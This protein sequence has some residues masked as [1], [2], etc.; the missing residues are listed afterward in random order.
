MPQKKLKA[1]P[2]VGSDQPNLMEDLYIGKA[3][4][5]QALSAYHSDS[6]VAPYNP[7]DLYQKYNDYSI[8]EDMLIDDQVSVCVNIK[9]DLIVGS[10][11][12]IVTEEDGQ[13]EIQADVDK[14]LREDSE[15]PI[16]DMLE[17]IIS[18]YNFGFSISE[19][20]F[21]NRS[22]GSLTL[23]YAK[24]RHP[25]TWTIHTDKLGNVE[26][27]EQHGSET[28]IDVDPASV[29]H[30]IN[31]PNW[32]N[33]YG[34]SDLRAAYNAWFTKRQ[35]IRYYAIFLEKAASPTP[36]AR[37]DKG[38]PPTAVT[39]IFNA[40]KK[41]QTN[42]AL[43]IPKDIELEFLQSSSAGEAYVK[44][45]NIFNMFIGRALLIPDLL[46]FQG[47]ETSGGSYSLGKDQLE[48][49][50][51]HIAR[52]RSTLESLVNK[53]LVRPIVVA[54]HGF[55]DNYPKFTLNPISEQTA[56]EL[57]KIWLEAQKGKVYK[58][59]EQEVNHFRELTGFP[60]G[61]VEIP[62]PVAPPAPFSIHMGEQKE[63][64]RKEEF[65][66]NK[67]PKWA[68]ME[69]D[70]SKK[71]DFKAL[72]VSM[73]NFKNRTV[74]A[75][76]PVLDLVYE[77]L[78]NQIQSKRIV[79]GQRID[80]LDSIDVRKMKDINLILTKNLREAYRDGKI[81]ANKELLKGVF[82]DPKIDDVFLEFL[83]NDIFDYVG[84]LKQNILNRARRA[85]KKAIL[86]G[87]SFNKVV[88]IL[89]EDKA[90][91]TASVERQARTLHTRIV[92]SARVAFFEESGIVDGYQYSAIMDD[93][94]S[95]ICAG[96][97]NKYFKKGQEPR[98]PLHF[99]C[100][101]VLIPITKFEKFTPTR[102]IQ[103]QDPEGF[104]DDNIGKDF[105]KRWNPKNA[106]VRKN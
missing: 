38:A 43:T 36:V 53:H 94:T 9:R 60:T 97:H 37:Y 27:Y 95:D 24:T 11:W 79:Q 87:E 18:A 81:T 104:I 15:L 82:A 41:L 99:N 75:V 84:D 96:L 86:D 50:F 67:K 17:E 90:I 106:R 61:E 57:A 10:G 25:S 63:K 65:A 55:I 20:V 100:R 58:P 32:Q 29:L 26:R 59:T 64:E 51:K 66:Q 30:Y 28:S 89:N 105:P 54:N 91:S 72:K 92:N 62:E 39:A 52:R 76:I 2:E 45:I 21:K 4:V 70:Y 88:E 48:I 33:P 1:D 23:K 47:D 35:I 85:T 68:P 46:G 8:Y 56:I 12:S 73:D 101:S 103:G 80:K 102:K 14:A 40:I 6:M 22:D 16:D 5:S 44:G 31:N 78:I 69:G 13:E 3:E 98:P 19:K 7:D 93:R 49:L 34:R 71:V 83:K 42:T 77:D 74:D